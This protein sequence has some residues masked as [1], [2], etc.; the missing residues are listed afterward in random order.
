MKTGRIY[1]K[2]TLVIKK[3]QAFAYYIINTKRK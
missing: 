2:A 3:K 1:I